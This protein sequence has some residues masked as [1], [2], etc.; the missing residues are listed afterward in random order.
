MAGLNRVQIIGYLGRD[1]EL[2]HTTSG[3]PVAQLNVAA[4]RKWK[5]KD[6]GDVREETEWFRVQCWSKL[7][8]LVDEHLR[9]GSQVYV[10]GRLRSFTYDDKEGIK[11]YG[12]EVV[13]QTVLF[14]DRKEG[15]R[16]PSHPADRDEQDDAYVPTDPGDDDIPF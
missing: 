16:G 11:R 9:K 1:P 4:S 6:G 2:R 8:E 12:T 15:G 10:D 5:P 13:A 14:L 7:A 3:T